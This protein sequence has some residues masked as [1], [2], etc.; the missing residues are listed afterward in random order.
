MMELH[1]TINPAMETLEMEYFLPSLPKGFDP[2]R[3]VAEITSSGNFMQDGY[4]EIL[5]ART[6]GICAEIERRC[7]DSVMIWS[8]V[9]I[10][11]LNDDV[12]AYLNRV[13]SGF[14]LLFQRDLPPDS[15]DACNFGF[16]VIRRNDANLRFYRQLLEIQR[17]TTDL[18]DQDLGNRLLH[19]FGSPRWGH[20]PLSFACES[21]G[22]MRDGSVMYHA[23]LTYTNSLESKNKMLSSALEVSKSSQAQDRTVAMELPAAPSGDWVERL[24]SLRSI[25]DELKALS[26]GDEFFWVIDEAVF[27]SEETWKELYDE[28]ARCDADLLATEV[29]V[30]FEDESWPW[31]NTLSP[32]QGCIAARGDRLMAALVPVLRFS[33]RALHAVCNALSAGWMGHPEV[34]IP[35][36]V[37]QA[38]MTVEDIGGARSFTPV[39]RVDRWY[40]HRTWHW[41]G[42]VEHVRGKLHHPV[43]VQTR[44]LAKER[45]DED[46]T[47]T[48]ESGWKILYASPI[49]GG[50]LDLLA[51]ALTAFEGFG[52]ETL[53]LQYDEVDIEIPSGVKVVRDKGYKWQLALKHLHP[54]SV[55]DYDFIFFWDDDLGVENFDPLRFVR[56]MNANR[57][58]MAQPAIQSPHGLSHAITRHRPSPPPLRAPGGEVAYP[59]V[60]RLTNF[61][62]IMAPVFTRD[63]WR[64]FYSYLDPDNRSGWGYDYI[65]L[66]RKGIVDVMPVVHTRP[67]QSINGASETDIRRFLDSQGLF[68]Y[69]PVEM[70]WLFEP[71]ETGG[72]R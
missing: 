51:D 57:L 62:E 14:D 30:S 45:V 16:Q 13:A 7:D 50:A 48:G 20:L 46:R 69:A 56:I 38:G 24:A 5:T 4:L 52:S 12:P 11:F 23:N 58:A 41:K 43:P 6:E 32:P 54:D 2:I 3:H 71:A 47:A 40:D 19:M 42:P 21:N 59:V 22:G 55:Q 68:R 72:S 67:V 34:L 8:D 49:G 63:A 15:H 25:L 17:V 31:W 60:G 66:G 64:E 35:T 61:V 65:P 37:R 70:G 27:A 10:V 26:T 39:E 9:D 1:Y 44:A 28:F 36:L 33:R 18:H 29:R 53:L